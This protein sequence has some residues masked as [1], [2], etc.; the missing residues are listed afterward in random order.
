MT[1]ITAIKLDD[2]LP[3]GV[4]PGK[5]DSAHCCFRTGINHAD[6]LNGGH[7]FY[8]NVCHLHL[9]LCR[10]SIT[11]AQFHSFLKGVDYFRVSMAQYHGSPRTDIVNIFIAIHIPDDTPIRFGNEWW[12][13]SHGLTCPY[14]AI[15]TT[16]DT[17]LGFLKQ[18][19]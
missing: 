4:A 15:Y 9:K 7:H 14:R 16:R 10:R 6:H 19:F 13:N 1:V 18:F 17:F 8:N 3:A 12:I 5:P 11:G 2:F